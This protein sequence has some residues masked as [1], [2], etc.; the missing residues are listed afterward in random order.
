[1]SFYANYITMVFYIIIVE[2]YGNVTNVR[3]VGPVAYVRV[4]NLLAVHAASRQAMS[5]VLAPH[6]HSL[7]TTL[8]TECGTGFQICV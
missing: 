4:G 5:S 7:E 6:E 3:L 2:Y 1:M 8:H